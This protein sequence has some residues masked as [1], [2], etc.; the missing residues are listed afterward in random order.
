MT[1]TRRE[2]EQLARRQYILDAA[3]IIFARDGYENASMNEIAKL[4]EFTKRTLYQYF[5]DK[6]DLYISTLLGLYSKMC[7]T[8]LSYEHEYS[9][10]FDL[11]KKSI[12]AYYGYY[13]THPSTFKIMY[14][15]GKVRALTKNEKIKDFLAIDAKLTNALANSIKLGQNDGS[16]SNKLDVMTTTTNFKFLLSATFDKLTISGEYY[17]KHIDKT[18]D[19]FTNDLLDILLKTLSVEL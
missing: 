5:A 18:I 17:A 9:N 6:A 7:D 3:E 14:D 12:Q 10:G 16:I 19:A 4:S 15:I 11:T 13:K 2:N 1:L 8:L